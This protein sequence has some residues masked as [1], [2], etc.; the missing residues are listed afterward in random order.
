MIS[1]NLIS[2]AIQYQVNSH[3]NKVGKKK[4]V[5]FSTP[6]AHQGNLPTPILGLEVNPLPS[7]FIY[8]MTP[9][10]DLARSLL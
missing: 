3:F 8:K 9:L 10:G 6:G 1:I 4:K 5:W 7:R 2:G